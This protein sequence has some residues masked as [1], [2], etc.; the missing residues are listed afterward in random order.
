VPSVK[1]FRCDAFTGF[2]D[3]MPTILEL[4]GVEVPDF[5]QG[6]S[7]LP[8]LRGERPNW[9][10]FFVTSWAITHAPRET[11]T[12]AV[13][14]TER[15]VLS[16]RPST[17]HTAEWTLI[18]SVADD[19][20]ELYH[21]ATDPKQERNLIRQYPQVAQSLHAKF[22]RL[23]EECGTREEFLRPRQQLKV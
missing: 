14:G 10:D 4:A 23:L 3:L 21:T 18:Y 2:V 1:P 8:F 16:P 20:A 6:K 5:V 11:I 7:L 19:D 13:D 22:V 12:R 9:R 17:I 15:L